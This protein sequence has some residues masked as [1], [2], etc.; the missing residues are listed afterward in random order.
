MSIILSNL[1]SSCEFCSKS[2]VRFNWEILDVCRYNVRGLT[3]KS[4]LIFAILWG[5]KNWNVHFKWLPCHTEQLSFWSWAW[6]GV[7]DEIIC[8]IFFISSLDQ[9]YLKSL[10]SEIS[11]PAYIFI[12]I[13][14]AIFM[15]CCHR[16]LF[17]VHF[18]CPVWRWI[19][20][21][22]CVC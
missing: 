9:F 17:P 18:G 3:L 16:F 10:I 12:S 7:L 19:W 4:P 6:I 15:G 14:I 1:I 8:Q 20:I 13:V 11:Q 5:S 2:F 22:E 21:C